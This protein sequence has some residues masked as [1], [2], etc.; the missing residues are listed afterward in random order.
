M[1][2][3]RWATWGVVAL[4]V[5]TGCTPG[6][7]APTAP[8]AEVIAI[9]TVPGEDIDRP[10]YPPVVARPDGFVPAPEGE[11]LTGYLAQKV[12]WRDCGRYQCAEIAAPLDYAA[13]GAQ[14]LTVALAR[15]RATTT[16]VLGTL[17][18]NPGGP[19]GSGRELLGGFDDTGLT[20]YDIV[21]WDPRGTGASTPVA[22]LSD[23]ATDALNLLDGS[24]DDQAETD[25]LIVGARNLARGCWQNSGPLLAHISTIDT[26]RDLDLLRR[27]LGDKKLNYLGYSYGTQ[28][29]ATYAELFPQH[30]GR[31]VLD[32][33][34]DIT[35]DEEIIQAMGFD[36][37]L[38]NFAA[39]CAGER[40]T[41]GISSAEVLSSITGL[42]DEL[43]AEPLDVGDRVLTQSLA[44][45]GVAA[46]LYGG[47]PAWTALA[48]DL[49]LAVS[50]DGEALLRASDVL[51]DRDED[52]HYGSMSASFL[53]ISC[54]DSTDKGVQDADRQW[55]A[56][57]KKAP[58]LAKYFG[59]GITCP[60]WP[61]RSAPQLDLR[62]R[63]AAP[64]LV[65]GATG[66]PATPYQQA[67]TMA[68]QLESAVLVTYE[69]EGH[70]TYGNGRSTCVDGLVRDYLTRGVTP[71]ADV[72]CR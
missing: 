33:A 7:P 42:F 22:C 63:G 9:S 31:L 52:G 71:D 62:G 29:G 56:D 66:D 48:R 2:T 47:V 21:G 32:A 26:V 4:L 28:I 15:K 8:A 13:P 68:K 23:R 70:A 16:P 36:K 67:V 35:D 43:D 55:L 34:V 19:G 69:G 45:T 14:A 11:G 50:G 53:A 18:I 40:C 12:R 6:A 38:S 64:L 37:A 27:L 10:L 5:M 65:I 60:L 41:L 1:A 57:Q 46:Y 39:W 17:F 72:R 58:I 20:G 3:R 30:T 44:V 54:L 59:P 51:N 24:P 49:T 61:V 25:A